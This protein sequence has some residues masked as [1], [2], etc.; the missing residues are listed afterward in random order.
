MSNESTNLSAPRAGFFAVL[1]SFLLA[2]LPIL[3]GIGLVPVHIPMWVENLFAIWGPGFFIL[4]VLTLGFI[5]YVP[6]RA[7]HDLVQAQERQAEDLAT[8]VRIMA[9]LTS[10]VGVLVVMN[11]KIDRLATVMRVHTEDLELQ[12]EKH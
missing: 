4:G 11:Q 10:P 5:R 9:E 8:L 12:R 2:L 1:T 3:I 7:I 6:P